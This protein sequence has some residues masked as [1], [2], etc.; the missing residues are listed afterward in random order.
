[1]RILLHMVMLSIPAL[2]R[3]S[4]KKTAPARQSIPRQ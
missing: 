3:E 1:M 4:D 2:V